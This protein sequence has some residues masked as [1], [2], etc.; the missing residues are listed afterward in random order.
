MATT[1][2]IAGSGDWNTASNWSNDVPTAADDAVFATG[3]ASDTITGSGP[4]ASLSLEPGVG[5]TLTLAGTHVLSTLTELGRGA[6]L[7][8]AGAALSFTTGSVS[9]GTLGGQAQL[10][11]AEGASL[12]SGTLTLTSTGTL[13]GALG[14][15]LNSIVV[16]D[17]AIVPDSGV[18]AGTAAIQGT[19]GTVAGAISGPGLLAIA[20]VGDTAGRLVLASDSTAHTG[21]TILESSTVYTGT[22]LALASVL[23]VTNTAALRAGPVFADSGPVLL[24]PGVQVGAIQEGPEFFLGT[25]VASNQDLLLYAGPQ[26]TGLRNGNGHATVIGEAS[27]DEY[28]SSGMVSHFGALSISGGTGSATVWGGS[29]GGQIFGGTAGHNVLVGGSDLTGYDTSNPYFLFRPNGVILNNPGGMTIGGGGEGDLLVATGTVPD[30]VAAS[31]GGE[32]LT[33][34]GSTGNDLFFGGSGADVIVASAGQDTIV[35]GSGSAAIFAGA[36]ADVIYGGTG[37]DY[38]QAGTG[39]ATLF[40]GGGADLIGAVRGQSGGSLVLSGFRV[41]TDRLDLQGYGGGMSGI[42]N[43]QVAGG[44]TALTLVDGTHIT[45]L[46]VANLGAGSF[47]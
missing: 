25:V 27:P 11:L 39:N 38:V 3:F 20:H 1:T 7:L 22:T 16:P 33:G 34:S 4:A 12:G 46:G 14:T 9:S 43:S 44:S 41:G 10:I 45:L 37:A 47:V 15:L 36:G 19:S 35:G 2:W 23:E 31:G 6:V 40:A 21:G 29:E 24:D 26:N 17:A 5:A 42:A 30:V 8:P 13:S 28:S 32:T 18:G